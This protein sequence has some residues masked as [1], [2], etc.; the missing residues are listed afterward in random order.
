MP[1]CAMTVLTALT[2]LFTCLSLLQE[3]GK[4]ALYYSGT[5]LNGLDSHSLTGPYL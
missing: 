3:L 1:A 2:E 4:V 5:Q